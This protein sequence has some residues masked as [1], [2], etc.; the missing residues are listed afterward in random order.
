MG[1][2][3]WKTTARCKVHAGAVHVHR[4]KQKSDWS[5][6]I[7]R[8]TE[9]N[10]NYIGRPVYIDRQNERK[11]RLVVQYISIDRTRQKSH[12]SSSVYR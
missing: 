4:T 2:E 5:F 12:W 3:D 8:S 11:V 10:K 9:R 1:G 7:Y 6:S